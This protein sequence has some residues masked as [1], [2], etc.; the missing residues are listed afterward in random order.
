MAPVRRFLLPLLTL[1]LVVGVGYGIYL[2]VGGQLAA[3]NAVTV[4]GLIG[5]EKE[6][7]FND[8]AVQ[9]ALKK[10]GITVQVEKAGSRQI[11]GADLSKYD[12]AFP[13]GVPTAEKI[14]RERKVTQ[15]FDTFYT[16]MVVASW[17]PILKLLAANGL[18]RDQGGYGTLNMAALLGVMDAGTRWKDLKASAAYPVGRS[19]LIGSTDVRKS[20]SAAMYLALASYA[21]NG[22]KVVQSGS[23]AQALVPRL[24]PL[25]LRQGYQENSSAGPFEDYLALG[26][27]KAPLVMVYESQFVERAANKATGPDMLLLYPSP[28]LFTKHVLVPLTPGGAKLGEALTRDPELQQLAAKYGFR[29]RDP[30]AFQ[31]FVDGSGLKLPGQLV[32]VIDP[33]AYEVTEQMIQGIEKLYK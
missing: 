5:S 31:T 28:T 16:P 2:S 6:D 20:N 19:V 21:L 29:T 13:S 33:P 10:Q 27:G 1:L 24:A 18:A 12:F 23:E 22:D 17:R 26:M 32:D 30:K 14:R 7:F 11:A 9:A 25:F 8:P 15:T 3:R 4:R